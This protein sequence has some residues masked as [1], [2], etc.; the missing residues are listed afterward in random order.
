[1]GRF[2]FFFF[3]FDF[4]LWVAFSWFVLRILFLGFGH[5]EKLV[6]LF[7]FLLSGFCESLCV[8]VFV[9]GV[10]NCVCNWVA[11]HETQSWDFLLWCEI[12]RLFLSQVLISFN[13]IDLERVMCLHLCFFF[14]FSQFLLCAFFSPLRCVI[15]FHWPNGLCS[16][17]PSFSII[18]TAKA[19]STRLIR[20]KQLFGFWFSSLLGYSFVFIRLLTI[21]HSPLHTSASC[22][23]LLYSFSLSYSVF[24]KEVFFP[25]HC[26]LFLCVCIYL[27]SCS[28]F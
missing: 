23:Q 12:L 4:S 20:T 7:W 27:L 1:M 24:C 16:V 9:L 11:R 14:L 17:I 26:L 13:S 5:T 18:V 28:S 22:P 19:Y 25:H 8:C 15:G 3:L 21:G 2:L 6:L 10:R